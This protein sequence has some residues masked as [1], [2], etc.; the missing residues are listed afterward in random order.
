MEISPADT[1]PPA[2]SRRCGIDPA[3][4]VTLFIYLAAVAAMW[5][6]IYQRTGS[7]SYTVDDAYIHGTLAKN[8]AAHGSFGIIPGEF[9][10]ASSSILWTLV[11]ATVFLI[12]GPLPW[13][14][15]I[16]ATIFGA[17]IVERANFLMRKINVHPA[18]R[19]GVIILAL[20]Y[21]PVL[22]IISTGME[23]TFHTWLMLC[24]FTSL[25]G[26]SRGEPVKPYTVFLW[27]ALAAGARYESLFALPPLL[28]WLAFRWKWPTAFA[29]GFGMFFPVVTFAAY[30]LAHGGYVLPNSLMLKGNF[31]ETWKPRVLRILLENQYLLIVAIFLALAAAVSI[32]H[33]G[34]REKRLTWLPVSALAMLLIHLQLAQ[35]GWFWRY[36]GYLIIL[37]FVAASPL[38]ASIQQA[39]R[40]RPPALVLP[41]YVLLAFGTLPLCWR[42]VRATSEIRQAAGN[43][44][45]QQLQ[46]ARVTR[47]L[48]A[49]ARVA[50]N[51]LGAISLLTD[52]R[53]LDLIGLGD[54]PLA[55]A[56][57]SHHYNAAVLKARIEETH[58]DF[59]ICY[60]SWFTGTE[61]LPETMIPVETWILDDN[62][63]CGSDTVV[64]YGTSPEAA[65][66]LTAAL[67]LYRKESNQNPLSTNRMQPV[68]SK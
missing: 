54:N 12:T 17:L 34:M 15:G 59:V 3:L 47:H 44:S 24:L 4:V 40:G 64:F 30:S 35:L 55:R 68:V 38:L 63:I 42:S 56:K 5:W 26:V 25:V 65:A 39:L 9:S 48:G 31:G 14:P 1:P 45:D 46:M 23:H 62:L 52:A 27:A 49:G 21:A 20:A 11:L 16:M 22:P 50:V 19:A 6:S 13:I 51:D 36:E 29:L 57:Y 43:I 61:T 66:K 7:I 67:E 58:T 53:V 28:L 33:R 32:W 18:A 2:Q 60:P 41:L 8:L 37:G 10:A